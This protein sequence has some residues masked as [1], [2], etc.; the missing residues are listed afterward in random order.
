MADDGG[1]GDYPGP[2]YSGGVSNIWFIHLG[3]EVWIASM[4]MT[5]EELRI[6]SS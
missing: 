1:E 3:P 2:D 5:D 6:P 4:N